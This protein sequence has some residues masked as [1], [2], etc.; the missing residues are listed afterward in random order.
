[1][2]SNAAALFVERFP[3]YGLSILAWPTGVD[4]LPSADALWL[5]S[6]P[7]QHAEVLYLYGLGDGSAAL[8]LKDWLDRHPAHRLIF[9]EP[10]AQRIMQFLN[11][12][13]AMQVLRWAQIEI[14]H[15]PQGKEKR[16][17]LQEMADRYPVRGAFLAQGPHLPS[18]EKQSMAR[19]KLALLRKTALSHAVFVDQFMGH[20]P[21]RHLVLNARHLPSAFYLNRMKDSF[22]NI[23]AIICGAGPSLQSSL[24]DL[25]QM[26]NQALVF[27]GGSAIAA[28]TQ[29]GISPHFAIAIDPNPEE[30]R[31]LKNSFA[32]EVPFL[33]TSRLFSDCFAAVNGP[34]GYVRSGMS[35]IPELW[36]DEEMGLTEPTLGALLSPESIS[37]TGLSAA[38]AYFLGC[39]PIIFDGLDLAYTNQRRYAAGVAASEEASHES[40]QPVD[41]HLMKKDRQG[42][43][44]V[45]AV[46]WVME[47]NALS[48]MARRHRDRRWVNCTQGGIGIKGI[49]TALL[50]AMR[51]SFSS[52][53]DL[54]AL[55]H[56]ATQRWAMPT[57]TAVISEKIDELKTSLDRVL[58][59]LEILV[60]NDNAGKCALA[61][62][63]LFDEEAAAII[64][65]DIQKTI[66]ALDPDRKT[67]D[68]KAFQKMAL[69]CQ[70]AFL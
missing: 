38:I 66:R 17:L 47:A 64:F 68:W 53:R 31:R 70:R 52:M 36:L 65:L 57:T 45:S 60:Q 6:L 11:G 15:L 3:R 24:Y 19:T 44:V 22:R 21:L 51:S 4:V 59:H 12:P 37:V 63:E 41:R 20:V 49:E 13:L 26:E 61:E 18:S 25:G 33:F 40:L 10:Q 39:D 29:Q 28:L 48:R 46:R 30:M 23:P 55:V 69:Q 2:F 1:M 14:Y 34:F 67:F 62:I 16:A 42:R 5:G 43:P 9:L 8:L 32:F 58:G 35:G 54:R 56:S 27:A 7:L 50:S